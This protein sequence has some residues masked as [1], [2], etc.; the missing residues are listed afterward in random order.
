VA[1]QHV[2]CWSKPAK[3]QFESVFDRQS[4]QVWVCSVGFSPD[5][6]WNARIG[7]AIINPIKA[8]RPNTQLSLS[9]DLSSGAFGKFPQESFR[10]SLSWFV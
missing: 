3:R 6:S 8:L 2:S 1:S 10:P 4:R 5:I 9:T 7:T